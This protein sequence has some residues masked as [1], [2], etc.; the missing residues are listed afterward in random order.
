M[1]AFLTIA[2]LIWTTMHVYVFWRAKSVPVISRYVPRYVLVGLACFLWASYILGHIFDHFHLGPVARILERIGAE[3]FGII[4]LLLVSLLFVDLITL[5]GRLWPRYAPVLRGCALVAAGLLSLIAFVQG[6]RAPVIEKYEVSLPK[7]PPELDGAVVVL[8]SD[9]HLGTLLQGDWLEARIQQIEAEHPDM[10]VLAGDIVEG[11][12]PSE[13]ELL[14]S[15]R[16]LHAPLGVWSVTGNHEF[17][18]ENENKPDVLANSGVQVLHDR[19]AEVRPGLIVAGI[20]DLTSRHRQRYIGN[21]IEK[22]LQARPANAATILVSHTPWSVETAAQAGV[23]LMLS[24]HTHEGQIW[25]FNYVV[26]LTHPF[27]AGRYEVN[28]M[29]LVVCRGTGTWGPRMR[30][31]RRGEIARITLRSQQSMNP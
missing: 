27:L 13:A 19:W 20:D 26:G 3:W 24:G 12:N 4:F 28:G 9:F 21:S 31:W 10:I 11:E 14:P 1:R 16:M 17:D 2:L 18:E 8:A 6:H 30:L 15:L 29:P 7:L 5:F 22:V 23:S 25:P